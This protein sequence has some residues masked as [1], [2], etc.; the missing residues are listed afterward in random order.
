VKLVG[1][2]EQF[3][4]R[5]EENSRPRSHKSTQAARESESGVR[6]AIEECKPGSHPQVGR[7][8]YRGGCPGWVDQ[9][10]AGSKPVEL[11]LAV[12]PAAKYSLSERGPRRKETEY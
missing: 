5:A 9:T 12:E 2:M 11:K 6:A 3:E 10:R 1:R 4:R 7:A 8:R